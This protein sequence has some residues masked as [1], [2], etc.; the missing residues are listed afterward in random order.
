MSKIQLSNLNTEQQNPNTLDIDTCSTKE[1]LEKINQ[2][3]QKVA[4]VVKEQ[5]PA[6]EKLADQA[7]LTI[8]NGGRVIYVGAGTSGRL[9]ILDASECPPTYGVSDELIQGMIAGGIP[10]IFKAQEGAE[11][12][13][14]QAVI[15]LKEKH[16][17][18]QDMV[19]G[20]AASGRTPYVVS[21]IEYAD[22]IGARTGSVC[23]VENGEVT[24]V[25]QNPVEVVTGPEVVTGSTRMK[26]GTA[27]KLVL[28]MIST[29]CMI[30]M[31]KVYTNLMVDVQPTNAKLE[32]RACSIIKKIT[33]VDEEKAQELFIASHKSVKTAIVMGLCDVDEKMAKAAIEENEGH[34]TNTIKS[35][36]K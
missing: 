8:K 32:A 29:T 17:T 27:Q 12:S 2:E 1:I 4:D 35:L 21:A 36:K 23:C 13:K 30:K 31:G 10:A 5:I 34:L 3:D 19:I 15:D 33:G 11:D 7:F 28:N 22:S 18:N 6:I 9:G 16:L 26:A 24:K 14:E 25:S 20:L